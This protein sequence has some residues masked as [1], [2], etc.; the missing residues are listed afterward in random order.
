MQHV[1]WKRISLTVGVALAV[2]VSAALVWRR[3]T[4]PPPDPEPPH[5]TMD[6]IETKVS[7]RGVVQDPSGAPAPFAHLYLLHHR[8][9]KSTTRWVDERIADRMGAYRFDGISGFDSSHPLHQRGVLREPSF[10]IVAHK[11]GFGLGS[12]SLPAD[13]RYSSIDIRLTRASSATGTVKNVRGEP[14]PGAARGPAAPRRQLH[15][16]QAHGRDRGLGAGQFG[17]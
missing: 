8:G 2:A 3:V 9:G 1:S 13:R 5:Q 14:L 17:D 6:A 12:I 16:R 4:L 7:V 15:D 10:Q 11:V